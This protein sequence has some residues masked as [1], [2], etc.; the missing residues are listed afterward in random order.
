MYKQKSFAK[1]INFIM[2]S[3]LIYLAL[4]L[5]QCIINEQDMVEKM[6]LEKLQTQT[7]QFSDN[8]ILRYLIQEKINVPILPRR[9]T[10]NSNVI[11]VNGVFAIILAG[12]VNWT[13]ILFT[14][15]I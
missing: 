14:G 13:N 12:F 1:V 9:S 6:L 10:F 7:N 11:L 3:A 8:N 5:C 15:T 4:L 2:F